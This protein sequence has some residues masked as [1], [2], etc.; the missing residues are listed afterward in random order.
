[1]WLCYGALKLPTTLSH[2]LGTCMLIGT[3]TMDPDNVTKLQT[4]HC[5]SP[6]PSPPGTRVPA[7]TQ[8]VS[9]HGGASP[10]RRLLPEL[11]RLAD[12]CLQVGVVLAAQGQAG[13]HTATAAQLIDQAGPNV[14]G[15]AG[16]DECGGVA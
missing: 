1:M 13:R 11:C 6:S 10:F 15:A 7:V 5:P 12:E 9:T 14:G 3:S 4:A 8:P 16:G 2:L